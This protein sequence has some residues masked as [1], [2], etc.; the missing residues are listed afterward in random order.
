MANKLKDTLNLSN[1]VNEAVFVIIEEVDKQLN[2]ENNNTICKCE[3]CVLDMIALA[4]NNVKPA[5]RST[6]TGVI[7][8]QQL[9]TEENKKKYSDEVR[10]AIAKIKK[11]PSHD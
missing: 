3:D 6:L 10:K 11:N 7:Y 2:E 9:H 1:L 5:Y 4:L 8:A